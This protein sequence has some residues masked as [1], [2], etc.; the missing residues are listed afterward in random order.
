MSVTTEWT[1]PELMVVNAARLLHNGDVV[2]VGVGLPNLA[3]NLA[4]RTHAPDLLMVYESGVIG[5][6]PS[7]LPLSIGDPALVEGS[8]MVTSMYDLFAHLLQRGHVSVGFLGGAQIDRHGNINATLIG[9]D[10]RHPK[11]RLPGSGGSQEIAAWA[12]RTYLMARHERRRFPERCDFRTSLG[13]TDDQAVER[14]LPGAGPAALVTDLGILAPN[15]HGELVLT[16][17][18]PGVRVESVRAATG[19][20][21][22]VR[23]DLETTPPPTPAEL[24]LLHELDP[25]GIYLD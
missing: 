17:L 7:R 6:R 8:L 12:G 3:C 14:D 23:P 5:A 18:H 4:L 11:V 10:Y 21:L 9:P 22:Q 2:L 13:L 16:H 25:H 20:D 24:D 15:P 1:A 19:W